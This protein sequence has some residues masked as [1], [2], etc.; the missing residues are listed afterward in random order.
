MTDKSAA[1]K[2]IE[3]KE[4]ER[5]YSDHKCGKRH[6]KRPIEKDTKIVIPVLMNIKVIRLPL[7]ASILPLHLQHYI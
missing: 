4:R 1:V 5:T 6:M 2:E 3:G 7:T